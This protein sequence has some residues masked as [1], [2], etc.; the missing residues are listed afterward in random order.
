MVATWEYTDIFTGEVLQGG[1]YTLERD[2][3]SIP[4]FARSG[5]VIPLGTNGGNSVDNPRE[6][7]LL[8]YKEKEDIDYMR[9]RV[10]V[11]NIKT[12]LML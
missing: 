11:R 4:V 1:T 8:V 12:V 7:E 6:L 5:S 3:T 10:M 9:T 2:L